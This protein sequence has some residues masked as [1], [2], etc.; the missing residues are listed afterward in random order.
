MT[1]NFSYLSEDFLFTLECNHNRLPLSHLLYK[2]A[3]SLIL[4]MFKNSFKTS[5]ILLISYLDYY[6]CSFYLNKTVFDEV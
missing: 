5:K 3:K 1:N 4:K 6:I 2:L